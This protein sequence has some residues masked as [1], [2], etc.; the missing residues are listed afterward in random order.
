MYLDKC[1][2]LINLIKCDF[3]LTY[4]ITISELFQT[5][6]KNAPENCG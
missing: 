2:S 3:F 4:G 5:V 1:Q 6:L